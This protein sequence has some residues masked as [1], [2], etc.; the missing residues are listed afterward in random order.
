MGA[1]VIMPGLYAR[2][3]RIPVAK[4]KAPPITACKAARQTRGEEGRQACRRPD[5]ETKRLAGAPGPA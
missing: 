3:I 5:R 4:T 1:A 2:P